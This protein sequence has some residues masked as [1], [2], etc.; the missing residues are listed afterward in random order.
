M[1][2]S[3][4]PRLPV[5]GI[6]RGKAS[7]NLGMG[8][9]MYVPASSVTYPFISLSNKVLVRQPVVSKLYIVQL[10]LKISENGYYEWKANGF[11]CLK[12]NYILHRYILPQ[13]SQHSAAVQLKIIQP[14][15]CKIFKNRKF[16]NKKRK[17]W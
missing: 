6:C 5:P 14:L 15:M 17:E 1:S 4:Q 13:M 2:S 3:Q 10:S 9:K 12:K 16:F 7:V 11:K 8:T